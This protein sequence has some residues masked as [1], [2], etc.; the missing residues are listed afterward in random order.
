MRTYIGP[1][2][3]NPTSVTRPILSHG[4]E[5]GDAVIL[6]RPEGEPDDRRA[7]ETIVDIER[8]LGALEPNVE[9][10]VKRI[11]H[12]NSE[13]AIL[14]CRQLI[15]NAEG[16]RI[17]LLGGGARDVLI[18]LTVAGISAFDSIYL[19]LNFSDIDGAVREITLPNLAAKIQGST[20][21]TLA[22]IQENDNAT[23]SDLAKQVEQS[24]STITRHVNE[25][26]KESLVTT[27]RKGRR[28]HVRITTAGKLLLN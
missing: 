10:K 13:T 22:A 28:K 26:E 2:G 7:E 3:F 15:Q 12:D 17:L 1:I 19:V 20:Q 11:P 4:L 16:N 5:T 8:N 21:E 18:P 14:K 9:L 6:V 25:L 27:I 23:I 24:K